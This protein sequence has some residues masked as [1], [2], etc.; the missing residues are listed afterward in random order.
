MKH[1]S[2]IAAIVAGVSLIVSVSILSFAL[3]DYGRSLERAAVNQPNPTIA[4]PSHFT[5]SFESGNS[6]VRL[7]VHHSE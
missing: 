3:K 5:I 6:P 2:V 7:D 1:P 4:I